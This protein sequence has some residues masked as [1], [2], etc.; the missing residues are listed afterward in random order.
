MKRVILTGGGT[1]G[2]CLPIQVMF[3]SLSQ[4]N[5]DCYIV[6]D[7]RGRSFFRSI[8]RDKVITIWQPIETNRRISQLIN[9]PILFIQSMMIF[10]RLKPNFTIGFGG[11]ITFPFLLSGSFLRYKIAAHESNSILGNANKFLMRRIKYLFTAFDKTQNINKNFLKKTIHVGMPIRIYKSLTHMKNPT[12]RDFKICVI[13]GSQGAKSFSESIPK[14]IIR[15]Q[16]ENNVRCL[17]N[18]QARKED[19]NLVK[20]IYGSS[21]VESNVQQFFSEMPKRI[22]ESDLVISR[23]GSS[24]VSEIIY[25]G[26]PS[27]LIPYPYAVD[28]HQYHNARELEKRSISKIILNK[29]LNT[30]KIYLEILKFFKNKVKRK[31]IA[32]SAPK[33]GN[34]NPCE[35]IYDLIKSDL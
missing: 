14:A 20:N 35:R 33:L 1:G 2:H 16:S 11:F 24:T 18:H 30:Q 22:F 27:I 15:L 12:N 34:L 9:L 13:G 28:D 32:A 23:S 10:L 25:Y 5:I 8:D 6:T 4:K 19:L 21:R 31:Y 7:Q 17:V 3:N 29:N 26:K